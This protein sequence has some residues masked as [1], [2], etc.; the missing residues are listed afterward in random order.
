MNYVLFVSIFV[1][2]TIYG[3]VSL[4]KLAKYYIDD[5]KS[6]NNWTVDVGDKTESDFASN[7]LF[8]FSLVN[9][10]GGIRSILGQKEMNAAI[11][12][13][14]GYLI[15]KN[16]Y[17]PD[18]K[19]QQYVENISVFK[20]YLD[21]RGTSLVYAAIPPKVD[22]DNSQL[23]IGVDDYGN[24]NPNRF[25]TILNAHEI[26]TIDFRDEWDLA[27]LEFYDMQFKTDHHW[28][29]RAGFFA[30]GILADYIENATGKKIDKNIYD[31]K[32]YTIQVFPSYHLGSIGKRTGTL[33]AGID[34]L[35]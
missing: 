8:N 21:K 2:Q 7:F 10:N 17:V 26:D 1:V 15:Q 33:F 16:S 18:W 29:T 27:S 6:V 5:E 3:A 20:T 23:P 32:N 11:K 25:I 31:I 34:D 13:N 35:N 22:R 14:N 28:N 9:L 12:L 4:N 30:S 24:D 19:L